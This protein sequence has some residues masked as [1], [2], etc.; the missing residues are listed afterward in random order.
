MEIKVEDI[1]LLQKRNP[2]FHSGLGTKS[3]HNKSVYGG[4]T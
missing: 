3:C 2:Y 4:D 1:L